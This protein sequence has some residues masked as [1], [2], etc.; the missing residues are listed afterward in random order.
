[1]AR[2]S[3]QRIFLYLLNLL[4][5]Q[6]SFSEKEKEVPY[7]LVGIS[8]TLQDGFPLRDRLDY[9]DHEGSHIPAILVGKA[10][11]RGYKAYLDIKESGWREYKEEPSE[12][13]VPNAVVIPTGCYEHANIYWIYL[14]AAPNMINILAG[15]P[16]FLSIT[17]DTGM[18]DLTATETEDLVRKLT[19]HE[20]QRQGKSDLESVALPL[21][22]GVWFQD[23]YIESPIVYVKD[24]KTQVTSYDGS[25]ALWAG[26]ERHELV[27]STN[28]T[29]QE[30]AAEKFK[31]AWESVY[32]AVCRAKP[33]SPSTTRPDQ[34]E[35]KQ[36][37]RFGVGPDQAR[38]NYPL[39]RDDLVEVMDSRL[40]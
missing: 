11:V 27:N 39:F 35:C 22:T 9:M 37:V 28:P 6:S 29:N 1:M 15:E 26:V 13:Q 4:L 5:I 20:I 17:P 2:P 25:L 19:R 16:R 7:V 36:R 21:V 31:N 3:A 32:S 14:T 10:L 38:I 40:I 33:N 30:Q 12:P 24:D 8:G 34:I 18:I 23:S